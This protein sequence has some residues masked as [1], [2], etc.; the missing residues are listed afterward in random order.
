MAQTTLTPWIQTLRE[1]DPEFFPA[2]W[3]PKLGIH[4]T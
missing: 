3:D 2:Q 4:V 1:R